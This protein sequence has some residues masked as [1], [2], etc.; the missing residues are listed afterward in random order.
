[1]DRLFIFLAAGLLALQ[2]LVLTLF[3]QPL[4]AASGA[5]MLW[6]GEV[7]SPENSQHI[8]D[9]Y[10]LSHV[11]HGLLFYWAL[12]YFFPRVPVLGRMLV[13]LGIEVAWEVLENTPMIIQHYR[14][15]A[16]AQGYTGDSVL[17]SLSDSIAMLIGFFAARKFPVWVAVVLGL[18]FEGVA[19]Y[20]IRDNLTLNVINLIYPFDFIANWQLGS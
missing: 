17:N 10:T 16:L 20:C 2:A 6:V 7:L 19:L 8:S 3:G 18:L 5:V 9:W 13:A 11:V 4:I 14:E 15:Q 12:S 1:M